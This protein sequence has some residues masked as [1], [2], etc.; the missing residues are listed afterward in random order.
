MSSAHD[1][2]VTSSDD[3]EVPESFSL[4]QSKRAVQ[5]QDGFR[6]LFYAAQKRKKKDARRERDRKLKERAVNG[7]RT[8]KRMEGVGD[9]AE[10]GD[11]QTDAQR[12]G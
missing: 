1:A 2:E 10:T 12:R 3:E 6:Q 9:D 7:K 11:D 5:E 4:L 8:G